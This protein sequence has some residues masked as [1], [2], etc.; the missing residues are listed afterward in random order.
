MSDGGG[1]G[2][3]AAPGRPGLRAAPGVLVDRIAT[4][5]VQHDPGWRLPRHSLLAR[6]YNA[7]PAEVD[8][9]L[10]EL[11]ARHLIRRLP[12]GRI[13]RV[14]PVDYLFPL[15]GVRG[16]G[17]TADPLG[18]Q[19]VCQG[20]QASLREVPEDIAWGLRVPRGEQVGFIRSRW[21]VS[22]EPAAVCTTYLR[23]DI[24]APLLATAQVSG[25]A[26]SM[27]LLP[28]PAPAGPGEGVQA[29]A[30]A[31]PGSVTLELQPPPPAMAKRLRLAAGQ[32][33]VV[34]TARFDDPGTRRPAALTVAVLR[35]DLFRIV[36][37]TAERPLGEGG[38]G[39]PPGAAWG[40][41]SEPDPGLTGP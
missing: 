30:S 9:A 25:I 6:R 24:A 39:H 27:A 14:S 22:G 21:A 3:Q 11:A 10:E 33:A 36:V 37:Q 17:T 41:V 28:A 31:K 29:T 2:Q 35:P 23:R 19:V 5:V 38:E 15:E 12:D 32:P 34:M 16:L 26:A 18:G 7:A 1:G 8:A 40:H 20:L 13:C 4:E